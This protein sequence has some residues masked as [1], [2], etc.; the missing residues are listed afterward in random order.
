[1]SM[2]TTDSVFQVSL[3]EIAFTLVLLMILLLGTRYYQQN[4]ELKEKIDELDK[5]ELLLKEQQKLIADLR[6]RMNFGGVCDVAPDDPVDVMMP[7]I[8]CVS[9][10]TKISQEDA[11]RSIE[12]GRELYSKWTDS[13]KKSEYE[14]F[15]DQMQLAATKLAQGQHLVTSE[16]FQKKFDELVEKNSGL[17]QDLANL[18]SS[19]EQLASDLTQCSKVRDFFKLRAGIDKPPC[20]MQEE[21]L[22][23]EYLFDVTIL[24]DGRYR[25]S[26]IWPKYREAEAFKIPGVREMVDKR[27]LTKNNFNFF[28][29]KILDYSNDRKP[30]AC[31]FYVQL[32]NLIPD[33]RTADRARLNLEQFFYK[34]ER[35]R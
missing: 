33:R 1:M 29:N 13:S 16:E 26:P 9:R 15:V 8:N 19:R 12:L 5:K 28:A 22:R 35:V 25:V 6:E 30:E 2:K 31:R 20:W 34:Y 24:E 14:D 21:T 11:A 32:R 4:L 7:C 3:T 17:Q 27:I 18:E 10:I 23:P